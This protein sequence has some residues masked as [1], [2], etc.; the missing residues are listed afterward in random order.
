MTKR[1]AYVCLRK[2]TNEA[3]IR[4]GFYITIPGLLAPLDSSALGYG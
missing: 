2:C 3:A 1:L 4:Q